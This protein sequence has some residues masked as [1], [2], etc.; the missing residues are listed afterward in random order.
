ME[1]LLITER[2]TLRK[3]TRADLPVFIHYRN[4]P[5]VARYQS[6]ENYSA[7]DAEAFYAQQEPLEF[8]TDESWFQ[9][10]VVR[11]ED[12][13]LLGDVAV[14]FFDDG[15]QAELGMTFDVRH[16]RQGFAR[17]AMAGVIDLLFNRLNKHRLVA[18][19]DARNE[20]AARLLEK[21]KFRREAHFRQNIFFKG[22]WGD[23]YAW[24]LLRS[25]W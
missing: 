11:R 22:E 13:L 10:A 21:L 25:E 17:E 6:W 24:A 14:H 9:V 4:Q 15:R 16:Q 1:P 12:G 18:T 7:A 5:V 20:A 23:E 3:F 8:N 2:L 19:V